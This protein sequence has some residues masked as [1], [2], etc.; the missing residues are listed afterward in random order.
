MT[1]VAPT[2][3]QSLINPNMHAEGKRCDCALQRRS[4]AHMCRQEI[5]HTAPGAGS[6]TLKMFCHTRPI[7]ACASAQFRHCSPD[8][9]QKHSSLLLLL[10]PTAMLMVTQTL[11]SCPAAH[12]FVLA[13]TSIPFKPHI[14]QQPQATAR[15][16][17]AP[18]RLCLYCP[19]IQELQLCCPNIQPSQC[20]YHVRPSSASCGLQNAS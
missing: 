8:A 14:L 13:S 3:S 9:C 19:S 10:S 5:A 11:L 4:A 6:S 18:F 2:V 7:S 16:R 20:Q 12:L 1:V 15:R 17:P